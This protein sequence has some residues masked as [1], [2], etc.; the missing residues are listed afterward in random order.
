MRG[1]PPAELDYLLAYYRGV[2]FATVALKG[3]LAKL[4][5]KGRE[6]VREVGHYQTMV[7]SYW[8]ALRVT[9][10]MKNRDD[11]SP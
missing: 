6:G 10:E 1:D 8:E 9:A 4:G 5:P 7:K 11:A 3:R 2:Y